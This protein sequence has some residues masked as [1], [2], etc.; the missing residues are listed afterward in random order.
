MP[1]DKIT[2]DN[3]IEFSFCGT[4]NWREGCIGIFNQKLSTKAGDYSSG[5]DS[6]TQSKTL[7]IDIVRLLLRREAQRCSQR[8]AEIG[9]KENN[10]HILRLHAF[11]RLHTVF[12]LHSFLRLHTVCLILFIMLTPWLS[13]KNSATLCVT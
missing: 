10:L 12:R 1:F 9:K 2:T 13:A 4:T 8:T 5:V 11:L 6:C 3:G 7:R